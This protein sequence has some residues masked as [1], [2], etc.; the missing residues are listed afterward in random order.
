MPKPMCQRCVLR[1]HSSAVLTC[2]GD[3]G[4]WGL[5]AT[6]MVPPT[7][8]AATAAA[9]V[10]PHPACSARASISASA[11]IFARSAAI[12]AALVAICSSSTGSLSTPST[13]DAD[14]GWAAPS[15]VLSSARCVLVGSDA[16]AGAG[17]RCKC[18]IWRGC[19]A[20]PGPILNVG[21]G[22]DNTQ[23]IAARQF[24]HWCVHWVCCRVAAPDG[25]GDSVLTESLPP[26][27]QSR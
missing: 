7:L 9:G 20:G 17:E 18:C 12:S 22:L 15:S 26:S 4:R 23:P 14:A 10:P 2:A 24:A 6:D 5:L 1:L 11:S 16:R 3:I 8:T 25:S 21:N 27:I 19:A 13:C